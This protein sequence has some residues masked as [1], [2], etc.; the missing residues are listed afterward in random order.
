MHITCLYYSY[1]RVFHAIV[2]IGLHSIKRQVCN[3]GQI[4]WQSVA[5]LSQACAVNLQVLKGHSE[6]G[7]PLD[8][9]QV[10]GTDLQAASTNVHAFGRIV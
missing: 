5:L 1:R 6:H 8:C 10:C 7:M 2:G 4:I 9:A 3:K